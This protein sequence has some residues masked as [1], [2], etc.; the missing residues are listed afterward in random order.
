MSLPFRPRSGY[1]YTDKYNAVLP[2]IKMRLENEIVRKREAETRRCETARSNDRYFQQW[3]LQTEKFDDWTSPRSV[4]LSNRLTKLTE[5]EQEVQARREKLK[6]LYQEDKQKQEL[7]LR[8]MKEDEE[9]LKWERMK[10]KVQYFRQSRET[11]LK[12]MVESREHEQW[13]SN[14]ASF[15]EFESELKK[16]Q[17][18]EVWRMQ[19]QQREDE[20]MRLIEEKKREALQI[21]QIVQED[22]KK[23]EA[24]HKAEWEK[25][26]RWKA[27][28]DAQME[29]L[30]FVVS[31]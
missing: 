12:E 4:Q 20:K 6:A 11:K 13:K 22:K 9:K 23:E 26:M 21:Q 16:Q 7:A 24:E 27:D 5:T 15:K 30:K 8:K 10:D 31:I 19:L 28:L 29:L 18:Q 2:V 14:S 3:H 1:S 17:Q 25:K